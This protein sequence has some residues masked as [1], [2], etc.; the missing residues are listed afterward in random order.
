MLTDL[1]LSTMREKAIL[2]HCDLE[3]QE[4]AATFIVD[5]SRLCRALD[6][7]LA[8]SNAGAKVL[9]WTGLDKTECCDAVADRL[10]ELLCID[11]QCLSLLAMS[12]FVGGM[13]AGDVAVLDSEGIQPGDGSSF[14]AL[15]NLVAVFVNDN[16]AQAHSAHSLASVTSLVPLS[17][18]GLL[19]ERELQSLSLRRA[20]GPVAVIADEL[21]LIKGLVQQLQG[22]DALLIGGASSQH[23]WK[24]VAKAILHLAVLLRTRR[25]TWKWRLSPKG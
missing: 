8:L 4:H 3:V 14:A 7:I 10:D 18:G 6:T 11:T 5:E 17:V 9:I 1:D 25:R 2:L 22:R 12:Y 20:T 21:H 24:H 19:V 15:L 16:F 23:S 13:N